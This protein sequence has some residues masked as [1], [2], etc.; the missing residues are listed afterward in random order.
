MAPSVAGTVRGPLARLLSTRLAT[1]LAQTLSHGTMTIFVLHR[2]AASELLDGSDLDRI[3]ASIDRLRAAGHHF[4]SLE[5]VLRGWESGAAPR[6]GAIAFTADDGYLDQAELLAPA[7]EARDCPLT[8]FLATGFLDRTWMPW[9]DTLEHAVAATTHP[10]LDVVFGPARLTLP[11]RTAGE[12]RHAAYAL[13][14]A[15]KRCS[16]DVAEAAVDATCAALEVER[17]VRPFGPYEPM[18]WDQARALEQ[19]GLVRFGPHTVTHPVLARAS[20]DRVVHEVRESWRRLQEELASPLPVFCYPVGEDGDHGEREAAVVA[21]AGLRGAVTV[22]RRHARVGGGDDRVRYR[23]DR[24]PFW[25]DVDSAVFAATGVT[26]WREARRSR[27][28]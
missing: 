27:A 20:A 11:L 26:R 14:D 7:F 17:P 8:V 28:R 6:P 5:E 13:A 2:V 22:G 15:Y 10:S 21:A 3:V 18:A 19:R 25:D 23:L 1:R 24:I 16:A 4:V 9:W 12:R